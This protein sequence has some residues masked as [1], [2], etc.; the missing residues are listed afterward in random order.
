LDNVL[1]RIWL[2]GSHIARAA[3]AST[4]AGPSELLLG[5]LLHKHGIDYIVLER[6]T[7]EHVVGRIRASVGLPY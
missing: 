6:H 5:Q 1:V 2:Q 4:R 3:L 7:G